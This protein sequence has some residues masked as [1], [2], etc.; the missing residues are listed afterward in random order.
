MGIPCY[1]AMDTDIQ[2]LQTVQHTACR[3]LTRTRKYDH[4]SPI[5]HKIHWLTVNYR[6]DFKILMLSDQCLNGLAPPYQ[7]ELLEVHTLMRGLR[8][9]DSLNLKVPRTC[10]KTYGDRSF[11]HPVL[12]NVL[13]VEIKSASSLDVFTSW[14]KIYLF[15]QQWL[16]VLFG[17]Y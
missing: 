8:S 10:L 12:W 7:S 1:M 14:L 2:R 17:W 11:A 9:G 5:L 13:P 3:I 6:V 15:Q 16:L 4:I